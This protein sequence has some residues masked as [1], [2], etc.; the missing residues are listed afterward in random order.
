MFK[1]SDTQYGELRAHDTN[2]F[3]GAVC[4]QFLGD[5]PDMIERPG[6]AVIYDR[7]LQAFEF[8]IR[9]GFSSTPHVIRLM[10]FSADAPGI[11]DDPVISAQLRR[12][13][14]SPEQRLDDLLAVIKKNLRGIN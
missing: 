7:M 4:D 5:R 2:Q 13:G 1:F 9:T 11:H 14:G 12:K 8:S 3:V 10:Y 6:S